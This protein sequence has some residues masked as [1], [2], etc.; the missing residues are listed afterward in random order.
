MVDDRFG[1]LGHED[2]AI[3][4]DVLALQAALICGSSRRQ[5]RAVRDDGSM[6]TSE[7]GG[8]EGGDCEETERHHLAAQR[9]AAHLR[10]R[11]QTTTN[12]KGR[13]DTTCRKHAA[14]KCSGVLGRASSW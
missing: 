14:G 1:E 13:S 9:M 12:R 2:L 3:A 4:V 11:V 7:G 10:P 8:A 5:I 6:G